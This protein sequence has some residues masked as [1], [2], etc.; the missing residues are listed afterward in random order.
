LAAGGD[1]ALLDF[2]EL[3]YAPAVAA[4]AAGM[5][6]LS[7][8]GE[9]PLL[10]FLDGFTELELELDCFVDFAGLVGFVLPEDAATKLEPVRFGVNARSPGWWLTLWPLS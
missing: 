6:E 4:A 9:M 3:E 10:D 7:A 1:T 5:M 2:L 8:G